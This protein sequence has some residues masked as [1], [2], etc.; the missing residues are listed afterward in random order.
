MKPKRPAQD[1]EYIDGFYAL[2]VP[3][4]LERYQLAAESDWW[5]MYKK[6]P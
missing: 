6:K 5:L 4:M 1:P 3:A 2:F